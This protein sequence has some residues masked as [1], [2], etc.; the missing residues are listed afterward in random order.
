VL[1]GETIVA[2]G[3]IVGAPDQTLEMDLIFKMKNEP[4]RKKGFL[5]LRQENIVESKKSYKLRWIG[6]NLY[7]TDGWFAKSDPFLKIFRQRND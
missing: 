7:N 2:L 5:I 1:L 3:A 4:E 6:E